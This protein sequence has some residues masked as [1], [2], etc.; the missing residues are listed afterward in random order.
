MN[1]DNGFGSLRTAATDA[2]KKILGG[3]QADIRL[4]GGR[5]ASAD[6]TLGERRV[7]SGLSLLLVAGFAL[8]A[9][10]VLFGGGKN[11]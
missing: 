9:G 1:P 5:A 6:I 3:I 8:F 10:A 2:V 7:M 4:G 11:G